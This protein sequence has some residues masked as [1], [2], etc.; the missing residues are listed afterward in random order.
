[1]S[2]ELV[3]FAGTVIMF[4]LA[5]VMLN[6]DKPKYDRQARNMYENLQ[7]NRE[8]HN[9]PKHHKKQRVEAEADNRY[10]LKD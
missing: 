2:E 10:S 9:S 6:I 8:I 5:F 7:A 1:M 4:V 3:F